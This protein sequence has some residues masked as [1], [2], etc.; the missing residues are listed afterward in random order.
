LSWDQIELPKNI[1]ALRF[2]SS[3]T[4]SGNELA[5]IAAELAP[6]TSTVDHI[7]SIHFG[8]LLGL[9]QGHHELAL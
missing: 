8:P 5:R 4:Q 6:V 9:L 2:A 3:D 1:P 7:H